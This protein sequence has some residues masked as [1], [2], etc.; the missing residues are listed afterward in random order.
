MIEG[1]RPEFQKNE[2]LEDLLKELESILSPVEDEMLA[3]FNVPQFPPLLLIGG[4]RTGST[5]FM[6]WLA[7]LGVFSYPTNFLSRF[8][9]APYIGAKIQLLLTDPAYSYRN[10]IVDFSSDIGF[11][12]DLG[13]TAGALAP[14]DFWYFWRRFIPNKVPRY[15]TEVEENEIKGEKLLAEVAAI[16]SVFKKPF[17][18]KAMILE[19][20]IPFLSRLFGNVIFINLKRHPFYNIQSLLEARIKFFGD[21]NKWYSI[22]PKQ[23][24][25]LLKYDPIKQIAGQVFFKNMAVKEGLSKI[26]SLQYLEVEYEEYCNNP[27]NV[28][29]KIKRKYQEYGIFFDREYKGPDRFDSANTIRLTAKETKEIIEAYAE[30]SGENIAP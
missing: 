10:E 21:C 25:E 15:I 5:V 27:R 1:R 23:Y 26:N 24:H 12:S 9:Y 4:P 22:R 3:D 6:Q 8:F 19:Q 11:K 14:N 30:F 28:F 18:M 29:M 13:K 16:E 7:S 2:K 20:N 17:A